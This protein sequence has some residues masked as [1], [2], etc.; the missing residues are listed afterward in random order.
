MARHIFLTGEKRVGK[1]TLLRAY[2]EHFSGKVGGF[3]TVRTMDVFKD[4]FSVHLVSP[5]GKPEEENLLF[6]CP[7]PKGNTRVIARFEELGCAA[8]EGAEACD[9]ILMDELGPAEAEAEKFQQAVLKALDGNVPIIGVIQKAESDF[10]ERIAR[11]PNVDVVE[12]T[13]ENRDILAKRNLRHLDQRNSCGAVVIEQGHVLLCQGYRGWSFPKG[14]IE[15]GETPEQTAV[16]EVREETGIP[17]A[18]DGNFAEVVP[19]A[20]P[21]D[22]R[23]VTFFLGRS[24]EGMKQ[25]VA[26]E[27]EYAAWVPVREALDLIRYIPDRKVLEKAMKAAE[28]KVLVSACLLGENCKY[29]GGN[30]YDQRVAAYV[31]DKQ[32]IPVCP[33]RVLGCPRVPMEIREGVLVNREGETVDGPVRAAVAEIL[34]RVREEGIDCAVLK[35]RSPTCGVQQVYDGSF[36]GR[37][38]PGSGVLAQALKEAGVTV[39]DAEDLE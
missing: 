36:S 16:R 6:L 13:P 17:I 21:G 35:S 28:R 33:E 4:R 1:S 19:S 38:V 14:K 18:L 7:P 27:V 3:Q 37:L 20:K 12:V 2:L 25:P 34:Q 31:Q 22:T 8:L 24:L 10:L 39:T 9:L 30:N 32:V 5:D 26:E 11:H 29:N 23:T 15:P